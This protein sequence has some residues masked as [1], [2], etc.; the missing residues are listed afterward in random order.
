[1]ADREEAPPTP[2]LD[3][4]EVGDLIRDAKA[5]AYTSLNSLS[6][7]EVGEIWF[8]ICQFI[9]SSIAE[10]KGVNVGGL[11]IFSLCNNVP[12]FVLSEKFAQRHRVR[13]HNKPIDGS[14][15]LIPIN[16]TRIS[17]SMPY[18]R[19]L[20]EACV[21]ELLSALEHRVGDLCGISLTFFAIGH[22][23]IKNSR[24]K[25][26]FYKS[27]LADPSSVERPTSRLQLCSRA[28]TVG[29]FGSRHSSR[30][31]SRGDV[32]TPRLLRTPNLASLFDL[33][34]TS[35]GP[36]GD[37]E[38]DLT[39]RRLGTPLRLRTPEITEDDVA[40]Y[41]KQAQRATQST[42]LVPYEGDG[43]GPRD[44][45]PDWD[46]ARG[47]VATLPATLPPVHKRDRP[48]V[49]MLAQQP[50]YTARAPDGTHLHTPGRMCYVCHQRSLS[51]QDPAI[52]EAQAAVDVAET[53]RLAALADQQRR[54]ADAIER[55]VEKARKETEKRIAEFNLSSV[56]DTQRPDSE[57]DQDGPGADIF[58]FRPV[59]SNTEIRDSNKN[60]AADLLAQ[61]TMLS[62]M[63]NDRAS[64]EAL[65]DKDAR[66]ALA[67]TL[68][69]EALADMARK[70]AAKDKYR[71]DLDGQR[72]AKFNAD[73]QQDRLASTIGGDSSNPAHRKALFGPE[74]YV[75][76]DDRLRRRA[77]H[78]KAVYSS[79]IEMEAEKKHQALLE[80]KKELEKEREHL[81]RTRT[82]LR[83]E[84][85]SDA[86]EAVE[87]RLDLE[88][89]WRAAD[90]DKKSREKEYEDF[91]K[92]AAPMTL[93]EQTD[94][95]VRCLRCRRDMN[96]T[97]TSHVCVGHFMT[98]KALPHA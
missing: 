92:A 68:H 98:T 42:L 30:P 69:A 84:L 21:R 34:G 62:T 10:G 12:T 3:P 90:H 45:S 95:Y 59:T 60:H 87:T 72:Q 7:T 28:T 88:A 77:D 41:R 46:Y 65:A 19:D 71:S 52:K 80:K 8:R 31:V 91:R 37:L 64:Q 32:P 4:H 75:Q 29:S 51:Q 11:G 53:V 73:V 54:K 9:G 93:L 57:L 35:P 14:V 70:R 38:Q 58:A 1:M 15:P 48:A 17:S 55:L 97:G 66:M 82:L 2:R 61:S 6:D 67:Q 44:R 40:A 76:H 25:F 36:E 85:M 5:S 26:T 79:Q 24:V 20:I 27:F 49:P 94:D 81:S 63:K 23:S 96:N 39:P 22:L 56:A 78:A 89:S 18:D 33:G 50:D 16:Y 86:Q 13:A 43:Q 47:P 83:D 74:L